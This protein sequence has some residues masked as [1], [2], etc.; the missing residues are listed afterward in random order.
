MILWLRP[1]SKCKQQRLLPLSVPCHCLRNASPQAVLVSSLALPNPPTREVALWTIASCGT[2]CRAPNFPDKITTQSL[3]EACEE[4]R[5][6]AE[7]IGDPHS[8]AS[9]SVAPISSMALVFP[10]LLISDVLMRYTRHQCYSPAGSVTRAPTPH[11]HLTRRPI[12]HTMEMV[13]CGNNTYDPSLKINGGHNQFG[14]HTECF[15]KGY[16]RGYTQ[17][18]IDV[19]GFVQQWTGAYKAHIQ[20][21]LWHR[22][23]PA[24]SGYQM[25][26]LSQTMQ[27]G[28]AIGSIS[29]AKKLVRDRA[30]AAT[31]S[32]SDVPARAHARNGRVSA[33]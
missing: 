5:D 18:V 15:K 30:A 19:P 12:W 2:L 14:T 8:A 31:A 3:R 9:G 28:F 10:L 21:R 33:Q 4:A 20:Q 27:R 11:W 1:C 7:L 17:K 25:A 16:A 32:Q 29:L 6:A 13:H 23:S 24:P 26:T 22:D